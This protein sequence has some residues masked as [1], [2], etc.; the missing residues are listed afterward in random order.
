MS[1]TF[2]TDYIRGSTIKGRLIRA[3]SKGRFA[4]LVMLSFSVLLAGQ[5][6]AATHYV[7]PLAAS[8]PPGTGCGTS[9]GYKTIGAAITAASPD[10]TI[11][12]CKGLYA[13]QVQIT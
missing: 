11:M 12:V 8:S 9:A 4:S 13:E 1:S 2:Y 3:A 6:L 7:D 5:A 10:D